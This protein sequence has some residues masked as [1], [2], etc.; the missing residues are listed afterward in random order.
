MRKLLMFAVPLILA[1]CA[2]KAAEEP[3]APETKVATAQDAAMVTA[4]GSVPGDYNMFNGDEQVGR[5]KLSADG[6][7]QTLNPDGSVMAQGTWSVVNGKTCFRPEEYAQEPMC[8]SEDAPGED[9]SFSATSDD[10]NVL[11]VRPASD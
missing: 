1:G 9:G 3:A 5:A 7:Y 10:G 8:W 4:N 6:S 2:D 11:T